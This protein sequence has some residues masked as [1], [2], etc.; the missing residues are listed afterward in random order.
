MLPIF[1][2]TSPLASNGNPAKNPQR[3]PMKSQE[4]ARK[5][6]AEPQKLA[7][8]EMKRNRVDGALFDDL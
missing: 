3:I 4:P 6:A 5:M 7:L 8:I 2:L 1:T